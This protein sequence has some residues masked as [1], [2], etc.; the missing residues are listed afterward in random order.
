MGG[1]LTAVQDHVL[2]RSPG[3]RSPSGRKGLTVLATC[4]SCKAMQ[5]PGVPADT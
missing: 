4:P 3:H 2:A 1:G 5:L